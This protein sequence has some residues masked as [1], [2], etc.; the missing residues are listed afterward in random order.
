MITVANINGA[1]ESVPNTKFGVHSDSEYFYFF[2]SVEERKE[3]LN[4]QDV[5]EEN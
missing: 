5:P 2:E 4:I 1:P 3:F